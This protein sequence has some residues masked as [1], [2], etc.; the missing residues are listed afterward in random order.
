MLSSDINKI[1]T[2]IFGFISKY[3]AED[4]VKVRQQEGLTFYCQD[5][6]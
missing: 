5:G 3:D 6:L 1:L 2:T 4:P